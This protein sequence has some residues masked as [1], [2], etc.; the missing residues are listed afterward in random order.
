MLPL[1]NRI[2]RSVSYVALS[3]MALGGC[4]SVPK[5]MP[6]VVACETGTQTSCAQQSLQRQAVLDAGAIVLGMRFAALRY[7]LQD[8]ALP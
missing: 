2:V 6:T 7:R 1:R 4:M 5:S 3:A 8:E